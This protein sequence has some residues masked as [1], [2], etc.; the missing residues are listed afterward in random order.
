MVPVVSPDIPDMPWRLEAGVKVFDIRVEHVRSELVPGRALRRL[1]VQWQYP[2]PD[3]SGHGR[4]SRAAQCRRIA[5]PNR[6]RCTGTASRFP[7][8]W[9][10]CLASHR[11][12]SRRAD[13]FAY[14][15]TLD[16]HGTCFYHSHMAMQGMMG[17]IGLFIVQPRRRTRRA[18]IVTSGSSAGMGSA[19]EQHH[20]E[21]DGDGVQLA[22]DER[23][24]RAR[25]RRRSSSGAA[26]ACA[27][28]A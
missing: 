18:S 15:F 13:A 28:A 20:P 8:T 2:G 7:S 25:R 6:S 26:S 9:T 16:Q 3:D 14:E 1:G 12:P 23:Q 11:T 5:F 17:P 27:S 19:A 22:D 4:R 21:H 10:A 24:V